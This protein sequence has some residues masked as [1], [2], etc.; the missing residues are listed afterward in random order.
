MAT[1]DSEI[2]ARLKS[3]AYDYIDMG[4]SEGG[5]IDYSMRRF[6]AVRGLGVDIDEGKVARAREKGFDVLQAD[7]LTFEGP[8]GCVRFVSMMDFLE[9]LPA[10]QFVERV[11]SRARR[12][13]RDFL[14]IRHPCFDDEQYL[15]SLGLC[16]YWTNW[17]ADHTSKLTVPAFTEIFRRLGLNQYFLCF[18]KPITH[19]DHPSVLPGSAP[20]DQHKYDATLHGEKPLIEFPK[21]IY[22]QIDW[23]VAL[24]PFAVDEW[25]RLC[26]DSIAPVLAPPTHGGSATDSIEMKHSTDARDLIHEG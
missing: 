5:S 19:S 9:H 10:P 3:G 26:A 11:L 4:C 14:F 25:N 6:Q 21:P 13:A 7:I 2:Y 23:L 22:S 20:P 15:Q 1:D 18:R 12:L 8:S 17:P 24:R 16:L